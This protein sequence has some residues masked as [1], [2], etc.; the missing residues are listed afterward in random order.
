MCSS[1]LD[2]TARQE[3]IEDIDEEYEEVKYMR[4]HEMKNQ[5]T[6]TK[7][8]NIE[9]YKHRYKDKDNENDK[10]IQRAPSKSDPSDL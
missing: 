6:K 5:K 2:Q 8:T 1:L 7:N 3:Y 9:K 4:R 10:D